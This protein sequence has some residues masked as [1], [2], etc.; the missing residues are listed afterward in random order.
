MQIAALGVCLASAAAAIAAWSR[1]LTLPKAPLIV[2][3]VN[4]LQDL[5][6]QIQGQQRSLKA[7]FHR[8][9][10]DVDENLEQASARL[11]R[12]ATR[13]SNIKRREGSNGP[14]E[15][16]SLL[17]QFDQAEAANWNDG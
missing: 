9:D 13:E 7:E 8:L 3:R 16:P 12:A 6:D 14:E 17:Q 5:L 15:G 4:E 1:V 2:R 10:S 11:K